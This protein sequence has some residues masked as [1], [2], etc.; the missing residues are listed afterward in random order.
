M[1]SSTSAFP[2]LTHCALGRTVAK[3]GHPL[4]RLVLLVVHGVNL[5]LDKLVLDVGADPLIDDT[6]NL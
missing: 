6:A 4:V 2:V 5:H 1:I 3:A